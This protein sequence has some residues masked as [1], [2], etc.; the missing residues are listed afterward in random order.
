MRILEAC[1]SPSLGGLEL[2]CLNI[3]AQLQR[4]GHE[5]TLWLTRD[6]KMAKSPLASDLSVKLF[7]EPGRIDPIF[8]FH[9]GR[10]IREHQYE[11]L[12]LHRSKD[13]ST[14]ALLKSPPR[15]MTL[16][17]YSRL[18]KRD[19]Y[20]RLIYRR[21][22]RLLTITEMMRGTVLRTLPVK[23]DR[24]QTLYH[25]VDIEE[26]KSSAGDLEQTRQRF[27]IPPEA[28]L[29]GLVGR[30]E[31]MKGQ[32]VLLKAIVRL[33]QRYPRL[34][35]IL[36]GGLSTA[37]LGY[38][39]YLADLARELNVS[40]RIHIAGFQT[41][42]APIFAALDLF[43]LASEQESFGLVLLEAMA[44]GVAVI[45]T[46]AGGVAEIIQDSAEGLLTSYG[47][48]LALAE[49]ISRLMD[50]D[51][52]R[53]RL[54]LAGYHTICEKFCLARHLDGLEAHFTSI[55]KA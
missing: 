32:E 19:L 42:T 5:V 15:L 38:D 1:F 13:L 25:G 43:V 29:V 17:M 12:H 16:H 10:L 34:H 26:L 8:A 52:L 21:L 54:A 31:P 9:A 53:R 14:F 22:D 39:N 45:A 55:V 6:S 44:Q 2:Y 27:G 20:H 7:R 24:V 28:F 23:P 4:R 49:A 36:V 51:A 3:A 33:Y 48:D 40:D 11:I 37:F 41:D 50:D 46:E 35:A 18:S 30:L 47:D